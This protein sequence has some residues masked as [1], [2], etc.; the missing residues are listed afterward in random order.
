VGH[1]EALTKPRMSQES[2]LLGSRPMALIPGVGK[3]IKIT[4]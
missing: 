3:S 1:S 2:G 4:N